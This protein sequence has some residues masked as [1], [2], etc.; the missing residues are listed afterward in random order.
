MLILLDSF[1]N[2]LNRIML[3]KEEQNA[4]DFFC[5]HVFSYL[6]LEKAQVIS[7]AP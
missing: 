6:H 4:T 3:P 5:R 7:V 2:Y 1:D